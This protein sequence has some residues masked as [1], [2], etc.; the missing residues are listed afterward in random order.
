MEKTH[1]STKR[2]NSAA[3]LRF[4]LMIVS[5]AG[6]LLLAAGCVKTDNTSI[7]NGSNS[8]NSNNANA[9]S[10]NANTA[11]GDLK[12]QADVQGKATSPDK[13]NFTVLYQDPQN[14]SY[15]EMN[16]NYKKQRLLE[17]VADELN[18][19]VSIP[20]NVAITFKECGEVNAYWQP[21]D[22]Q[23]VMCFEFIEDTATKFR[24]VV[25]DQKE[26]EDAV[27]GAITFAFIHELGH[28]LIDVLSLPAT[29]REEDS[30]DQLATYVLIDSGDD[31]EKMALN[32]ARMWGLWFQAKGGTSQSA[33]NINWADEH[34]L[35]AQRFFNIICW[36]FGHNPDKW[37]G[38]VNDPLP[39][40]R[41]VRCPT[42]YARMSK[43]WAHLL[44]PYMKR[45]TQNT[46]AVPSADN[47]PT[48]EHG[49]S[50]H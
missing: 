19:S 9:N 49:G 44:E 11:G 33:G 37:R 46:A 7:A 25:T 10:Q 45:G 30:V 6:S 26:Y 27:G 47:K 14:P 2:A 34:S 22:R 36:V 13:G 39:E 1:A 40:G 23:I 8:D 31:G 42:E 32:G 24:E 15:V 3:Q 20:E 50:E 29:G 12:S 4:L 43:A 48:P 41:A 16:E 28:C 35:D 38:L 5:L 21:R 18:A 17:E